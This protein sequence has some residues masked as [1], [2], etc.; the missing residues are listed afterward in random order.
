VAERDPILVI[1]VGNELRGDDRA[2]LEVARSVRSRHPPRI[3]VREEHG[4]LLR[5]LQAWEGYRTAVLIDA[6]RSGAKPGT[7]RRLQ[8][9]PEPLEMAVARR[10][11]S[12][13]IS[14]MATIELARALDRLPPQLIL[15]AIEGADFA[16]GGSLTTPV[17]AAVGS[18]ARAVVRDC[19]RVL[20]PS[21]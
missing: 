5:L 3:E 11:T 17:R 1:G 7:I 6:M 10:T 12:H 20:S 13:S 4:E 16:P 2:G 21:A 9:G 15:Y 18:V 8:V 19:R 14:L